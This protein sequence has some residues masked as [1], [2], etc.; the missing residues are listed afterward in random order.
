MTL[1]VPKRSALLVAATL[2]VVGAPLALASAPSFVTPGAGGVVDLGD[3][4]AYRL[5]G[6]G[7]TQ[8]A[9]R[10][11]VSTPRG[12]VNG[13]MSRPAR[14]PLRPGEC[15]GVAAVPTERSVRATGWDAGDRL[16]VALVSQRDRVRLQYQRLEL[17]HAKPAAGSP[18]VLTPQVKDPRGGVR[19]KAMEMAIGD[20]VSLGHVDM[21]GIYALSLRLCVP[22]PKPH[23]TPLLMEVRPDTP[24]GPPV[25]GP[26]DVANDWPYQAS[27]KATNG[28]PNCW[29]LQP[30]P[31]TGTVAGRAPELF[32]AVIAGASPVQVSSVDFNGTGAK[33][34][35]TPPSDPRGTKRILSHSLSGWDH[36]GC[37]LDEDGTVRNERTADP[38]GYTAIATFGFV[39]PSGCAL[40]Y[41]PKVHNVVLRFELKLQEFGDNG[42]IFIGGHEIQLRQAG[43]WLTGG[44]LGSNISAAVTDGFV[45]DELDETVGDQS[46]GGDPASRLKLNSY[47]DWSQVEVVQVGARYVV[48]INGRTVTDSKTVWADPAPYQISLQSQ[49]NFSYAY[50]VNGRFDSVTQPTLTRPSDWGNLSWRNVRLYQCRSVHDVVCTGGPGVKG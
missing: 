40:T 3:R 43:E 49:P 46:G 11:N 15:V 44:L 26:F 28:Y 41:K 14:D 35:D 24:D 31:V 25:V 27:T 23:V 13:G 12:A 45:P 34:V 4:V 20:V 2:L 17:E 38:S 19:D 9:V 39:G 50:G 18:H 42:G 6:S 7:C 21:T 29:Q 1:H 8:D 22:L 47:P 16:A 33:L 32:L 5:S 37:V 48:R 30:W 10:I 36:E